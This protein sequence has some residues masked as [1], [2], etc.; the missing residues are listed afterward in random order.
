[1]IKFSALG[2]PLLLFCYGVLRL[3]DGLDGDHGPGVAWNVGHAMFL[4]A[5]MLFSV[6]IV[7][8]HRR[9]RTP[10]RGLLADA[11]M[12]LGLLGAACFIL[13]IAGDLSQSIDDAVELPDAV[14]LL[15][16]LA[17]QIGLL[18]PL[19][20]LAATHRMPLWSPPLVFLGFVVF[21][22]NLDLLALGAGVVLV[23]L[24][25]LVRPGSADVGGDRTAMTGS[26]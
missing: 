3:V 26:K 10:G 7:G 8:L 1:M 16:P 23:G 14:M 9:V 2:A 20:W 6:L 21:A 13:V 4:L 11:F 25:P 22:A 5:V 15:G 19:V 24:A 18:A 17:F 12:V